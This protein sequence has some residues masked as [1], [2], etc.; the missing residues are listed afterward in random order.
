[1]RPIATQGLAERGTR[2]RDECA[3]AVR[4]LRDPC[5]RRRSE[6]GSVLDIDTE[7]GSVLDIDT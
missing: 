2:L 5:P 1:M 7:K 3:T 6:K 4:N